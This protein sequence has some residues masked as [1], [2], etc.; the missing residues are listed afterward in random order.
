MKRLLF[1][2]IAPSISYAASCDKVEID[3]SFSKEKETV[4]KSEITNLPT[5]LFENGTVICKKHI[6]IMDMSKNEITRREEGDVNGVKYRYYLSDGSGSVQGK[7]N[8]TLDII[9]D[10]RGSNWSTSCQKDLMNDTH[11]CMM[12]KKDLSIGTS[13]KGKYFI[14][15]GNNHYPGTKS[16]IRIDSKK[17]YTSAQGEN[18][19]QQQ[20]TS[21]IADMGEAE[22][23]TT[24]YTEWPYKNNVDKKISTY[25]LQ[26][27]LVIINKLF[28][29]M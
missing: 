2:L 9:S 24:R 8:N 3:P 29:S 1:A 12:S 13:G 20:V 19:T 16:M 17:P 28:D 14:L 5:P 11:W 27:G 21:I 23:I 4:E 15:V 10:E 22:E 26:E 7:P 25:G 18:F 6:K